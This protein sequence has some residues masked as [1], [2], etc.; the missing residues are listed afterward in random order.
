MK[1]RHVTIWLV[2]SAA[3]HFSCGQNNSASG[4]PEAET[5]EPPFEITVRTVEALSVVAPNKTYAEQGLGTKASAGKVF[6]CVQYK[7]KNTSN[8]A[9][10]DPPPKLVGGQGGPVDVNIGAT[11]HYQP[12]DWRQESTSSVGNINLGKIPPG[13]SIKRSRCFEV[14]ENSISGTKL[15]FEKTSIDGDWRLE[16][17]LPEVSSEEE[18]AQDQQTIALEEISV[19]QMGVKLRIPQGSKTLRASAQATTYSLVLPG[20]L[21]E[22]NVAVAGFGEPNLD[23]AKSSATNM[24]GTVA[25]GETLENGLHEVVLAPSGLLQTINVFSKNRSVRCTGPADKVDI[26]R[27]ICRSLKAN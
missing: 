3:T 20:G 25:G 11:S 22:I 5:I 21:R 9:H 27:E 24:G 18:V 2:L 7:A 19:D 1:T 4:P 16:I 26:L 14:A 6:A 17:P 23:R 10:R 15:L 8:E 12:A 13:Q